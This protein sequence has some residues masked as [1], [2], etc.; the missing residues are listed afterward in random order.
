MSLT[1]GFNASEGAG[2]DLGISKTM[3]GRRPKFQFHLP[4]LVI[5]YV[6]LRNHKK[7]SVFWLR[8]EHKPMANGLRERERGEGRESG[9]GGDWEGFRMKNRWK[10]DTM[11]A[12]RRTLLIGPTLS[13]NATVHSKMGFAVCPTK[14]SAVQSNLNSSIKLNKTKFENRT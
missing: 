13:F 8:K 11:R 12:G 7:S 6:F 1:W 10:R 3:V 9:R 2:S 14:I 4:P 5:G